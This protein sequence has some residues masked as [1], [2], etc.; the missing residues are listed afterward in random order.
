MQPVAALVARAVI[1]AL[2]PAK[3][4]AAAQALSPRSLSPRARLLQLLLERAAQIE[5]AAIVPLLVQASSVLVAAGVLD[6]VKMLHLRAALVVAGHI[7]DNLV[8]LERPIK[9]LLGVTRILAE[10]EAEAERQVWGVTAP[11]VAL[12]AT[13]AR[14]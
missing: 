12:A 4:R 10:A 2:F 3:R 14:V 5:P 8:L 7:T 6:L 1:A 11:A 13:A 9:V